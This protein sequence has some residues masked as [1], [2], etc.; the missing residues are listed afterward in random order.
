MIKKKKK[1]ILFLLLL[2]FLFIFEVIEGL[3]I[4]LNERTS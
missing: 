1:R 4:L 2:R 3:R